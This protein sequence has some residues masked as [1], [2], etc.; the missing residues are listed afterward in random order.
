[1]GQMI[2]LDK[3]NSNIDIIDQLNYFK[4]K[5]E[6]RRIEQE[7]KRKERERRENGK[8]GLNSINEFFFIPE[9]R[10]IGIAYTPQE[11][12]EE[13]IQY[14]T[15]NEMSIYEIF[16][17]L[18][19]K[20]Q[21][22]LDYLLTYVCGAD[23]EK[24]MNVLP[25][26]QKIDLLNEIEDLN[27]IN[28][29]FKGEGKDDSNKEKEEEKI[30][31]MADCI[32]IFGGTIIYLCEEWGKLPVEIIKNL[33]YR[34]FKWYMDIIVE[35]QEKLEER[36]EEEKNK[37]KDED[38]RS[39]LFKEK[40]MI[41]NRF[42]S[43]TGDDAIKSAVGII[44]DERGIVNGRIADESKGEYKASNEYNPFFDVGEMKK[45]GYKIIEDYEGAVVLRKMERY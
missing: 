24:I 10:L 40:G 29:M 25:V 33:T 35:R 45:Q 20:K 34:Q 17:Y 6:R 14:I 43:M 39:K 1:M 15:L 41:D 21:D 36:I 27:N 4:E 7:E 38:A 28:E 2:D 23:Y 32:R 22:D 5:N 30:T 44:K 8:L 31:T 11:N 37:A 9:E 26:E 3:W 18:L 19:V 16:Q 13:I 12:Q 42:N